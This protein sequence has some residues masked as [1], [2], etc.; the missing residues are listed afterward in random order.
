M[1]HCILLGTR[2]EIIK[3]SSLIRECRARRLDYFII[4]TNQHYSDAMDTIFFKDLDLPQSTY[5]LNIG[6]G[7]HG[8]QTGKMLVEIEKILFVEKPDILYV[9]GDTNTVMAGAITAVK[10]GIKIAHVEAGLRSYDRTMPEEINRIITDHVSDYLFTPTQ[11]AV[12][13]LFGEGIPQSK[14]YNVGNTIVDAV[15][16]GLIIARKINPLKALGVKENEYFLLTLHRPS[17]VDN[18]KT[19]ENIFQGLSQVYQKYG[20]PIIFPIHPRTKKQ[21]I[22]FDINLPDGVIEIEPVGF[23][24]M[25][26]LE[27][28]ARL[29]F[30]DSGG[31]QEEACIMRKRCITLRDNTE[32]PETIDVGGNMIAKRTPDNIL[33]AA[34]QMLHKQVSWYNP[35]GDGTSA[36]HILDIISQSGGD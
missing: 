33:R 24:E 10:I 2:P 32:R 1:K 23:L 14:I 6:S 19:L 25:L 34:E 13:I 18:R 15:Q 30:T 12:D 5:N 31:I 7:S 27:K 26:R 36:K 29:I 4:H 9:Q 22:K 3:L 35:F 11:K 17:N 16:E 21:V 8:E 20:L 28:G